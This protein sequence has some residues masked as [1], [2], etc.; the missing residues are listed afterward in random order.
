MG[1]DVHTGSVLREA[2]TGENA[3]APVDSCTLASLFISQMYFSAG[4]T[5]VYVSAYLDGDVRGLFLHCPIS[6]ASLLSLCAFESVY[7]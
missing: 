5:A 3:D 6:H 7:A 4:V 1:T 2:L